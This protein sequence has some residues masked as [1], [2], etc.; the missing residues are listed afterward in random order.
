MA[1]GRHPSNR[2]SPGIS[3]KIKHAFAGYDCMEQEWVFEPS[4]CH[5]HGGESQRISAARAPNV[6]R[7]S[8]WGP[9]GRGCSET[10]RAREGRGVMREVSESDSEYCTP[11]PQSTLLLIRNFCR[12]LEI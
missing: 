3:G 9:G 12:G 6:A 10:Y 8:V 5:V 1:H 7:A 11:H 2:A 4:K